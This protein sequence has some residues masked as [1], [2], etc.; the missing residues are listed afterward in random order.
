MVL[1]SHFTV[2]YFTLSYHIRT[3]YFIKNV[4]SSQYPYLK[5][6]LEPGAYRNKASNEMRK[7]IRRVRTHRNYDMLE[8][9][10]GDTICIKKINK[11]T[12]EQ[13]RS[14]PNLS[15]RASKNALLRFSVGSAILSDPMVHWSPD[16]LRVLVMRVPC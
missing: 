5:S 1:C 15:E 4:A 7:Q 13:D 12:L 8:H 11:N 6:L 3:L 9:R 14:Q 16:L 10:L 2:S